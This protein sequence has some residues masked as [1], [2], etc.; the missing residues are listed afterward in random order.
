MRFDSSIILFLNFSSNRPIQLDASCNGFQHLSLLSN[1]ISLFEQLNMS[2]SSPDKDPKDFYKFILDQIRLLI[3]K[4]KVILKSEGGVHSIKELSSLERISKVELARKHI[5]PVI[6]TKPYNATDWGLFDD[7]VKNMVK[8]GLCLINDLGEID[9][10]SV[11]LFKDQSFEEKKSYNIENYTYI[12]STDENNQNYL[13]NNDL[14]IIIQC[15]NEVLNSYTNIK[16]LIKYLKDIAKIYNDYNLPISWNLPTGLVVNQ[17]YMSKETKKI[18]PYTF[19]NKTLNL[20]IISKTK[21][22]SFKQKNALMPN[23]VHSLDAT[24]IVL[25]YNYL[26]T[27]KN[28]C[29]SFYSIHDCFGVTANDLDILISLII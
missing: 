15:Y 22:H 1:E 7:L 18:K 19:S 5:K 13:T 24:T 9:K 8:V 27:L 21:I 2:P 11:I 23:L 26:Y 12:F 4:K 28:K 6:M 29:V 16:Y 25:L 3:E 20:T 14:R 10:D 17:K